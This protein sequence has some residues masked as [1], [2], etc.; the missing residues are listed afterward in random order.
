MWFLY[1]VECADGTLYTGITTDVD[2]RLHEHNSTRKGAKY[3]RSRRPVILRAFCLCE[4]RSDALVK[5]IAFK[6]LSRKQ[7]ILEI[8]EWKNK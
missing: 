7:K 4:D 5:E 8:N 6:K 1:V 3:T 2:R